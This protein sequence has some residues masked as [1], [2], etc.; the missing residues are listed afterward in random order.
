MLATITTT[1]TITQ[2]MFT[3]TSL[4]RYWRRYIAPGVGAKDF[5]KQGP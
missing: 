1:I 3:Y 5:R 4:T 2:F